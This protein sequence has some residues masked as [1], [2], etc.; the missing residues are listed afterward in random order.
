M[1]FLE[2]S[3]EAAALGLRW[4]EEIHSFTQHMLLSTYSVQGR[5]WAERER[6]DTVPA[7]RELRLVGAHICEVWY[8]GLGT[9]V[10]E[11]LALPWE[12]EQGFTFELD[13][14]DE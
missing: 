14:K 9:H 1:G 2:K 7:L 12:A 4:G 6:E 11:Q 13:L 8:R 5:P 3:R 10:R